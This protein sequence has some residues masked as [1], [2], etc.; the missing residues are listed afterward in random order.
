MFI[1]V[2]LVAARNWKQPIFFSTEEWIQKIW[3]IYTM[4]CYSD[5]KNKDIMNFPDKW[6]K[7][8]KTILSE[9]TQTQKD[10]HRMYSLISGY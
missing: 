4:E 2:L 8:E 6:M 10:M 9:L 1:A 5:I 3:Y 7:L